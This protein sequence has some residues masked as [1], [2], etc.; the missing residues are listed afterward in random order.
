MVS[1]FTNFDDDQ[2]DEMM[3]TQKSLIENGDHAENPILRQIY[4][5]PITKEFSLRTFMDLVQIYDNKKSSGD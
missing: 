1:K 5:S 3:P 2:E 4:S